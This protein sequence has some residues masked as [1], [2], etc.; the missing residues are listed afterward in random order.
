MKLPG[1]LK[2]VRI[3]R[4]TVRPDLMSGL[5]LGVESVPDALASGV[6]AGINPL[7]ALYAVMLATPVGAFFA[8][9]VFPVRSRSGIGARYYLQ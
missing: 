9:S 1:F 7:F 6:L 8:S 3:D 5:V 4:R 2:R